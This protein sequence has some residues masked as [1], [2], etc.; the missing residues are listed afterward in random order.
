[1]VA[2]QGPSSS[3]PKELMDKQEARKKAL[4]AIKKQ[5][6]ADIKSAQDTPNLEYQVIPTGSISLDKILGIGGYPKGRVIEIYG[7]NASGKSTLALHAIAECQKMGGLCCFIDAEQTF[8]PEYSAALGVDLS[9]MDLHR[10]NNGEEALE[11]VD[12]LTQASV[13][14]LI[15]IDSVAALV[16]TKELEGDMGDSHV[17]LQARL[18]SQSLRKLVGALAKTGTT[19]IFLNQ[20]RDKIGV[21][22]G[23]KQTTS[24][25][26]ALKFYSSVRL[27]ISRIATLKSEDEVIGNRTRVKIE[28]NK[29][30]G[31]A[32]HTCEFD[33]YANNAFGCGISRIN[34][35]FE[36]GVKFNLIDKSG[37]WYSYNE[38]RLG[39]GKVQA[40]TALKE[41]K[42]MLRELESLV[43]QALNQGK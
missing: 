21:M 8:D 10:P 13:Y 1:M 12:I 40:V 31:T 19:L 7:Q 18:M 41:D 5:F 38:H 30:A 17:A 2:G 23:A 26:G 24:G 15:V 27:S 33:L 25:G 42:D 3:K 29:C 39:Q 22:F 43:V 6:G 20:L 16:P 14:D 34:E 35:L 32:Q 11:I 36:Y 9:T 28:K 4:A 37:A